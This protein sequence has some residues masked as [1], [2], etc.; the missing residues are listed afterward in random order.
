MPDEVTAPDPIPTRVPIDQVTA[1]RAGNNWI[2]SD[3]TVLP[4]IA[5][6][7]GPLEGAPAGDP[8]PAA[9]AAAP[10]APAPVAPAGDTPPV[11]APAPEPSP[12]ASD[13]LSALPES[14]QSHVRELRAEA[15]ERRTALKPYAEA[16]D[17]YDDAD[18][19]VLLEVA[20]TL[21]SDPKAAGEWMRSQAELLLAEQAAE[22]EAGTRDPDEPMTRAELEAF[23]AER[24]TKAAAEREQ[25]AH[26]DAIVT[27]AKALG[28][29]PESDRRGYARLL[30]VAMHETGGDLQ[31]AHDAIKAE[32]QKVID[33][34]LAAK[35]TA[36]DAGGTLPPQTGGAQE[37]TPVPTDWKATQAAVRN[38]L[39]AL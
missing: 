5:G 28:Y 19:E 24:E 11:G 25:K 27:E 8:T 20:R 7:D 6:G 37:A 31:K 23:L 14:W 33:E 17:G 38:R 32:R 21:K 1:T 18:R 29:D 39:A 30:D 9:P 26:V 12:V 16:F 10:A 22:V 13:D 3:G 35:A 34:Y 15:A 4:Y 36:G 2:Y